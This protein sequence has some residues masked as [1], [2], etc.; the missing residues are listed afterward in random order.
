MT[1][2]IDFVSVETLLYCCVYWVFKHGALC[3]YDSTVQRVYLIW[4]ARTFWLEKIYD[5][6][7]KEKAHRACNLEREFIEGMDN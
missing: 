5:L 7:E 2:V 4:L 1:C 6:R 3:L